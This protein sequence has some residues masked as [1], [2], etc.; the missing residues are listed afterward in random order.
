MFRNRQIEEREAEAPSLHL[1]EET[2]RRNARVFQALLYRN[3]EGIV[4]VTSEMILLRVVHPILNHTES[5]LIGLSPL[6]FVHPDDAASLQR[7]FSQLLAGQEKTAVCEFRAAD[8]DGSWR[9]LELHMTDLL[10]DPD[11]AA[12]LF[13]Y[14]D[15]TSRK[16]YQEMAQRLAAYLGCSEYAMFSQDSGGTILD[17]NSG[18][19]LAFGYSAVEIIGQNISLLIPPNQLDRE[20]AIRARIARGLQVPE[21]TATRIHRDGR[22]VSVLVKPSAIPDRTPPAMIQISRLADAHSDVKMYV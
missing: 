5:E 8:S 15:V 20:T 18:A 2:I 16:Q 9:W 17:W 3:Q 4:L 19:E 13:N 11:V 21:Y 10:D 14:R 1:L 6:S 12:I 22:A 7:A